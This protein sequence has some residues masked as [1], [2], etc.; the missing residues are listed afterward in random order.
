M[1]EAIH[2]DPNR[3]HDFLFLFDVELGNPNGDPEAGN[4]P[5]IDPETN[6]GLVTDVCIK[7]KIRNFVKMYP[8]EKTG[9]DIYVQEAG[10]LNREHR[11]AYE[12][13]R[14]P[15]AEPKDE[16][17]PPALVGVFV[18]EGKPAELPEGF[19]LRADEAGKWTLRY[20]GELD[21]DDQN[22][23][24]V[25]IEEELGKKARD[26]AKK[27]VT[28]AKSRTPSLDEVKTVRTWMC[29]TYF[30]IRLFG[31]V[32]STGVN[33]GQVRGPVQLTFSQ[34][35]DSVVPRDIPI[36]RMAVTR[37]EE[38]GKERTMGRKAFVPYGLYLGRGY[39]NAHFAKQ[40]VLTRR[41]LEVFWEA[42]A[43]VWGNLQSANSG[44]QSLRGLYVFSHDT[45]AG[46]APAHELFE[47]IKVR[48]KEGVTVARA[49]GDYEVTVTEEMPAG[50]TLTR[51][52]EVVKW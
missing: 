46:N 3:R 28:G 17:V 47:R 25:S 11:K 50:V 34:S 38:A 8:P 33:C 4:L 49:F 32:M 37:E 18:P 2:T 43:K 44:V 52:G 24:L 20:S 13:E 22:A 21:E 39:I 19:A 30:D 16:A 15:L 35:I 42:L 7:R 27:A 6:R 23:A 26:L 45:P 9:Y 36:T 48:R 31:A 5:R 29:R 40:T 51:L 1:S 14:I 12:A 10:V 41:D